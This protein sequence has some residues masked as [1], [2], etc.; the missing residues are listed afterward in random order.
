MMPSYTS[1][2]F[3]ARTRNASRIDCAAFSRQHLLLDNASQRNELGIFVD[4]RSVEPHCSGGDE[5]IR[6]GNLVRCL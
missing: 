3:T 2:F 5:S 6:Q 1:R 4:E